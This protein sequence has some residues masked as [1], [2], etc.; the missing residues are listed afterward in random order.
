[1]CTA[2]VRAKIGT[3]TTAEPDRLLRSRGNRVLGG[4]AGGVAHHLAVPAWT[5]R[6]AFV[7][8]AALGGSG[9]LAYGALWVLTPVGVDD[10]PL[11][12]PQR[13]RALGLAVLGVGLAVTLALVVNGR[14][15][16]ALVPVVLV[17]LG[18]GLVW[19][20]ADTTPRAGALTVARVVVGAT[21]IVVGLGVV[22]LSRVDLGAVRTGAVAVLATL[23]GV[24][25][26]AVPFGLRLARELGVERRARIR[27]EER[28]ELAAQVH[29]SV[30]QTL[31][32]IQKQAEDPEQVARLAR[33]Q[34]R[35]LR[36]WLFTADQPDRASLVAALSA[37]V[38]AVE[39]DHGVTVRTVTVGDEPLGAAGTALV[40]AAREAMV[41][42]AKHS[43]AREVDLYSEVG[44]VAVEVFVRDR[45]C[46]FEPADVPA[47]RQGLARSV[48]ERMQRH[49]GSAQVRS[50]PAR[51]TEV[52]LVL[53]REAGRG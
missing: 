7:G 38:T 11:S 15:A 42:A 29:D 8:L 6:V 36:G 14:L 39:D 51:G 44:S 19:R 49:G 40:A 47:D 17:A 45:G 5:V 18:A 37:A 52:C 20:A 1:M 24:A 50:S 53:P 12:S 31:A 26:L 30:L 3:M 32:L 33:R 48:T 28:A 13:R 21:L 27:T 9:V 23:V 41:N 35:E 2:R 22:V 10:E 25:L 4:V 34:E 16:A 43:G 46:G